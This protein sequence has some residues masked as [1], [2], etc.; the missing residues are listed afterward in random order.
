[1]YKNIKKETVILGA[2]ITG[3]AAG[4][5][6]VRS[7]KEVVLYEKNKKCGGLCQSF[8]LEGFTF[9]TFAH[10]NFS[11]DEYVISM[12]EKRTP[13]LIHIPEALNYYEGRWIRNPAQNNLVDLNIE[14]RIKVIEDFIRREDIQVENYED[15]LRKQYG[16]FFAK[17]FPAKYTRKYWTVEPKKLGVKWVKSRMYQPSLEEVLRGAMT[18]DTPNVHYSKEIHYP[19]EGGYQAFIIP[20]IKDLNI[21]VNK[22]VTSIDT[23]K[24]VV[25]F[26]DGI[27]I[28]YKNLISTI[29]L[30]NLIS[31]IK[32]VPDKVKA[33]AEKLDYTYGVLVSIALKKPR[34]A[35]ALWFYIYDEDIL[36]ARVYAPDIKSPNNVPQGCSALQ[37]EVYFSKYK[38]RKMELEEIGRIVVK[39]LQRMNLICDKEILFVD[40]R[41][42][43]YANIMFTPGIYKNRRIVHQYLDE[44]GIIYA[45]RFGEWDYLWTG[46]SVLS[47]KRAAEKILI[48]NSDS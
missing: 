19:K 29:P 41:E 48:K 5:T 31:C 17:N 22:E 4:H 25:G 23:D 3:L 12:F 20:F 46:Q 9:D 33:A 13:Y 27:K 35:P 37:A 44:V 38:P 1:M 16:N 47:G 36:P 8:H 18:K 14:E 6:L 2:G 28:E 21:Q 15:W 43:P 11:K 30:D 32:A 39:Q 40:I 42:E 7:Q 24:K 26:Q 34:C 10:V 45:G